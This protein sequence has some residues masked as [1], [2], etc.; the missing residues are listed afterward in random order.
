MSETESMNRL[1]RLRERAGGVHPLAAGKITPHLEP[2]Q[3]AFVARAPF[4]VLATADAQGNCDA[5]PKGGTPGFVRVVDERTLLL[6]D[7]HGNRLFQSYENLA[8]NPRVGMVFMIPGSNVTVRVNGHVS[9][10]EADALAAR[11]VCSER[12]RDDEP[13]MPAQGLLIEIDEAYFHC[14][15]SFQFAQLWDTDRIAANAG[16]SLKALLTE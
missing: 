5:S 12:L 9:V 16:K 10:L 1:E 13:E 14:P 6:P 3:A 4:V 15:R 8:G 11:E 7:Y 2:L